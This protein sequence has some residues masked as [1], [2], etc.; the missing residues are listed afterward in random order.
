M[1]PEHRGASQIMLCKGLSWQ[2]AGR[3]RQH[4]HPLPLS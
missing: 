1:K 4:V 2:R 3:G